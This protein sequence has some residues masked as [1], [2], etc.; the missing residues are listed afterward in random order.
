MYVE[1]A[2]VSAVLKRN[3][4]LAIEVDNTFTYTTLR[5]LLHGNKITRLGIYEIMF[6]VHCT[7]Q[8]E[9]KVNDPQEVNDLSIYGITISGIMQPLKERNWVLMKHFP[10]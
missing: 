7:T 8:T 6:I 5:N 4:L 9:N 2:I 1:M 10:W 3:M